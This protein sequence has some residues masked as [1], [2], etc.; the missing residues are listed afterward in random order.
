MS[1]LI[2]KKNG[3]DYEL[4]MLAEHYPADRVYLD[5]DINKTVQDVIDEQ[6]AP[7]TMSNVDLIN[8]TVA[9]G[10]KFTLPTNGYIWGSMSGS[11]STGVIQ[12]YSKDGQG[13]TY[14]NVPA[15]TVNMVYGLKGMKVCHV[16]CVGFRF[17]KFD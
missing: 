1:D 12:V 13:F 15:T 4:P 2:I 10:E 6:L 17:I 14:F 7:N 11:S 8:Y 3:T 16:N 9:S 5:G